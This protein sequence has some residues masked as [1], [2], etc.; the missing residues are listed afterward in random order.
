MSMLR[1][2]IRDEIR[3]LLYEATADLFTD[4]D[5]D[6]HINA[7]VRLLPGR[8]I[9]IE[10]MHTI[11]KELQ[12]QDYEVP[13]NTVKVEFLEENYGTAS[14]PDWQPMKGWDHY[15][16][17]IWLRVPPTDTRTMRAWIQKRFTKLT[18]DG[19]TSDVPEHQIDVVIYGA[20]IRA[21]QQL[22]GYLVD[23]KNYDAIVKPDGI[24]LGN[25]RGWI[26]ELRED[27]DSILKRVRQVRKPRSIDLVG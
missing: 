27:R 5:L 23:Q 6:T 1:S 10:E 18:S 7:E 16:G 15:A 26:R 19:Q 12:E 4:A 8:G 25:V 24:S 9:Y 17:A 2:E 11:A 20:A 13:D 3:V 22:V 14:N 21:Y